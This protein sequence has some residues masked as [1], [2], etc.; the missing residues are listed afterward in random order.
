MASEFIVFY[1]AMGWFALVFELNAVIKLHHIHG[2]VVDPFDIF[3]VLHPSKCTCLRSILDDGLG[4]GGSDAWKCLKLLLG[5]SVDI[6][7]SIRRTNKDKLSD[8][9][10]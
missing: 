1:F 7:N 4:S 8:N 9:N 10:H 2:V 6:D 5:S 3:Y